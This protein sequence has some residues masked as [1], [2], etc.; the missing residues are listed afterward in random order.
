[1][2]EVGLRFA[3][4]TVFLVVASPVAA[5]L[6]PDPSGV[7]AVRST[8]RAA[9][10]P[11]AEIRRDDSQRVRRA[12]GLSIRSAGATPEASARAFLSR[13]RDEL[14]L[15]P[16]AQLTHVRTI[17]VHGRQVVR[18][19]RLAFGGLVHGSSVIVRL[20]GEV[21]DYVALDHASAP[22][23]AASGDPGPAALERAQR[24]AL[25]AVPD[26]VRARSVLPGGIELAGVVEPVVVVDVAGEHLHQ[27]WRVAVGADG[28]LFVRPLTLDAQGRVFARNPVSDMDMTSDVELQFMTSR[29]R[30][31][32]RYFRVLNCN[33]GDRGCEP[34]Q[35]ATADV[36]GNFLFDPDDPSFVDWFAEVQG[37]HHT[38]R[39]AQYFRDRHGFAW[40]CGAESLMRVYV[41]YA[42]TTDVPYDNAAYSPGGG[43]ECGLMFFGQGRERDFVYD[44]DV[45]YHEYGHAVVDGSSNLGFFIIDRLGLAYDPGSFNE[46]YAD[47]VA[48]TVSGDPNMAEYFQGV[49]MGGEGALRNLDNELVCPDDLV[50]QVHAD[51]RIIGGMAWDIREALGAD[52]S[53]PLMYATMTALEMTPSLAD[54]AE[55]FLATADALVVD[56]I[57]TG[58]DRTAIEE[59]A[60]ARG[61]IGCERISPLDGDVTRQGYSGT[62]Q[63]TGNAG[64]RIAPVHYRLEIPADA[65]RLNINIADLTA[66]P[67]EYTI[68]WRAGAPVRFI[69]SRRPPVLAEGTLRPGEAMDPDSAPPLPRC[70]T[71]YIAITTDNLASVEQTM[72]QVTANLVRSGLAASC[73]EPDAGSADVDAGV[74]AD[75]APATTMMDEGCG[76][77]LGARPSG[78]WLAPLIGLLAVWGSRRRR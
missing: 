31:T 24:L 10:A 54:V 78:S 67:G 26:A 64:G 6:T 27:R 69:A 56:G 71:M 49:G 68:H 61:L 37:Y 17:E 47:Y 3:A 33:A 13:F 50:G 43:G 23:A 77:R 39:V 8:L 4:L 60:T 63:M 70:Q 5:Q 38:N 73:E 11:G 48:A 19:R 51:G 20:R 53:D 1:M 46:A 30:L 52:K 41:N 40:S 18:M 72:Y 42:E 44:S 34:Q 35:L 21:V 65:E 15:A 59:F 58:A 55:V 2:E 12:W 22:V 76:C 74:S 14:A 45:V 32:G 9:A 28:V 75:A 57:L 25:A 29:D 66:A 7:D 36:D 16:G 62:A